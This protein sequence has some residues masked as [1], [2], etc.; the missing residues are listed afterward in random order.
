[1]SRRK[2]PQCAGTGIYRRATFIEPQEYCPACD[3]TGIYTCT[4]NLGD[5]WV[6]AYIRRAPAQAGSGGERP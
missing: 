1:M 2:C 4:C 5:C 6:H 3:G